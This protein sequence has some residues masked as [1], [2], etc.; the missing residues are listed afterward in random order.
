MKKNIVDP[1]EDNMCHLV[2]LY[3]VVSYET[4]L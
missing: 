4:I 2:K 3:K 1:G